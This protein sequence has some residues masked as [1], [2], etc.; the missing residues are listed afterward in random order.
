LMAGTGVPAVLA[1]T[2]G[3]AGKLEGQRAHTL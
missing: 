2:Q 3:R 1:E